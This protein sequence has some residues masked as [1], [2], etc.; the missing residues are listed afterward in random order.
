MLGGKFL[1]TRELSDGNVPEKKNK[2]AQKIW[3]ICSGIVTVFTSVY[4]SLNYDI[5][6]RI[7]IVLLI[8]VFLY[9]LLVSIIDVVTQSLYFELLPGLFAFL[10]CGGYSF[11]MK[12]VF[13]GVTG[14]IATSIFLVLAEYLFT[15][16]G[17]YGEGDFLFGTVSCGLVSSNYFV[18]YWSL[19]S[20]LI[21]IY[22]I[23]IIIN[24][25][26]KKDKLKEDRFFP[27][28][29]VLSLSACIVYA[30]GVTGKLLPFILF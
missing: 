11:E 10:L 2:K 22:F 16:K 25:G 27:L 3:L 26:I 17:S 29:P 30:A 21:L 14:G 4:F 9:S 28:L 12:S 6:F 1:L 8:Y 5:N 18:H 19:A 7:Q 24:A 15:G 20:I 13:Y 23:V